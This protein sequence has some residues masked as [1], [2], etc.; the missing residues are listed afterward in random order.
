MGWLIPV[1]MVFLLVSGFL[2]LGRPT[3]GLV[4]ALRGSS[5]SLGGLGCIGHPV[6][7][8]RFNFLYRRVSWFARAMTLAFLRYSDTSSF[9]KFLRMGSSSALSQMED[10]DSN[11]E[12]M[13]CTF[14]FT[15][16]KMVMSSTMKTAALHLA[17]SSLNCF[18]RRSSW[19]PGVWWS[20]IAVDV[21]GVDWSSSTIHKSECSSC[22]MSLSSVMNGLSVR[23][24]GKSSHFHLKL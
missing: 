3:L 19:E 16:S 14:L 21:N 13:L 2:L 23:E 24:R 5:F 1:P 9:I 7:L 10:V 20:G 6:L 18:C 15:F 12:W 22:S 17:S 11:S 4:A 8:F